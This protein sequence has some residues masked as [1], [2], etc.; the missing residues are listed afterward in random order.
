MCVLCSSQKLNGVVLTFSPKIKE[1]NAL[2]KC[3]AKEKEKKSGNVE[4]CEAH[5]TFHNSLA[6]SVL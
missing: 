4:G 6:F 5:K 1:Q 2:G 3:V